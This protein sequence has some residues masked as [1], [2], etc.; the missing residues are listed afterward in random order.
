MTNISVDNNFRYQSVF[1]LIKSDV[2]D[3][4]IYPLEKINVTE[5][6]FVLF[7]GYFLSKMINLTIKKSIG[8]VVLFYGCGLLIWIIFTVFLQFTFY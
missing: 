3:W 2:P 8:Y 1:S 7:L 4:L 5:F 6:L